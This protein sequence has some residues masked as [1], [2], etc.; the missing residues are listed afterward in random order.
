MQE[1]YHWWELPPVSFLLRQV[2]LWKKYACHNKSFVAT[3]IFLFCRD[4]YLLWQTVFCYNKSFVMTGLLLMCL[5]WQIFVDK[6]T[7]DVFVATNICCDESCVATEIFCHDKQFCH[8]KSF[9]M[10]SVLL[11][12]QKTSHTYNTNTCLSWQN[13]CHSDRLEVG[14]GI[15]DPA[16]FWLHNGHSWL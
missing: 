10:A 2:L 4:K 5:L 13:F 15:C 9:V 8:N 1:V 11:S 3:N 12:Q 6:L 7:F 14:S 16:Q